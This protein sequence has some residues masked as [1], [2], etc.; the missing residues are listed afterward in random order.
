MCPTPTSSVVRGDAEAVFWLG[1]DF[2]V[3]WVISLVL[4]FCT[5]NSVTAQR[6]LESVGREKLSL[7]LDLPESNAGY[8]G[9]VVKILALLSPVEGRS[10]DTS[11]TTMG[12]IR[13]IQHDVNAWMNFPAAGQQVATCFYRPFLD[14]WL[15]G[16][17]TCGQLLNTHLVVAACT[18]SCCTLAVAA[19]VVGSLY[20]PW[21]VCPCL[22]RVPRGW[23]APWW[24][25]SHLTWMGSHILV[26]CRSLAVALVMFI[27]ELP[28]TVFHESAFSNSKYIH[29]K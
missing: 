7:M 2:N 11:S 25:P 10:Q 9:P 6:L 27:V 19:S 29:I 28:R 1:M 17:L 15:R 14:P 24:R 5:N 26:S 18:A 8:S 13:S 20:S 3:H 21:Q 16:R 22:C 4:K 23:T 12:C